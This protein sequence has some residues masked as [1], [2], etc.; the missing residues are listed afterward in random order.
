LLEPGLTSHLQQKG[1]YFARTL[2]DVKEGRV[3]PLHVFN[4]SDKVYNLAVETVV[5]LA[6][7]AY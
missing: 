3:V 6:K 1:F 7:A 5:A 4:V 2:V